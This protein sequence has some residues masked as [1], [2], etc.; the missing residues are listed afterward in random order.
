MKEVVLG[1]FSVPYAGFS[2]FYTISK[3]TMENTA[4][5]VNALN[6]LLLF[7]PDSYLHVYHVC[8]VS[9]P[10]TGFSYFYGISP[11]PAKI[12]GFGNHFCM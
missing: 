4:S 12:K 3:G 11:K 6:G 8:C 10:L 1:I 9:M 5:S 7:L 2:H